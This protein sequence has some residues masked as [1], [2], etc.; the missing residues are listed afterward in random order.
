MEEDSSVGGRD[1]RQ[2][3]AHAPNPKAKSCKGC[4][5]YSSV[6]KSEARNPLC[7]GITRTLQQVPNYSIG[8]SE[9][10]A[11]QED[12]SLSDFKYACVGYSVFLNNKD[13]SVEKGEKQPELPFCA[14][15]EILMDRRPSTADHVPAHAHSK[16]DARVHS[17]P[18]GYRP[19]QSSGQD[20]FSKFARNAGLVASGVAKNLI[21]VGN[22]IKD[23]FDDILYDR[24]R[25]K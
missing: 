6:L 11:T 9:I 1:P 7:V 12:H 17:H 2:S 3:P 14:G 24:R 22:Q 23:N 20:F 18:Q 8:E 25:P 4:L 19:T 16:E 21:R 5:F 15:L 10:E 13:S